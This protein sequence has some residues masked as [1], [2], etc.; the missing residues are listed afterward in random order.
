MADGA[1]ESNKFVQVVTLGK[2]NHK[3]TLPSFPIFNS[4]LIVSLSSGIYT[5]LKRC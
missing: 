4:I 5:K 2:R 1:H 3:C